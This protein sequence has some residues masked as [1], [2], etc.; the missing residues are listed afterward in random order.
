MIS[1]RLCVIWSG[2]RGSAMHAARRSEVPLLQASPVVAPAPQVEPAAI[3]MTAAKPVL[4]AFLKNKKLV[5]RI[6][7][8]SEEQ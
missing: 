8:L 2:A 1:V 4:E 5:E 7:K 3:A 6:G